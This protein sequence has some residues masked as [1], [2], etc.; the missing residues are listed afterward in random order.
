[1]RN[2]RFGIDDT[3]GDLTS[4]ARARRNIRRRRHLERRLLP[5]LVVGAFLVVAWAASGAGYFWPGWILGAFALVLILSY[6][7]Y[8]RGPVSQR[9]V[10]REVERMMKGGR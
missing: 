9:D 1:M 3:G 7:R 6:A 10:D 5:F 2:Q 8:R 4:E